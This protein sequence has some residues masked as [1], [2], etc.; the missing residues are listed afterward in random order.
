MEREHLGLNQTQMAR[1]FGKHKNTQAA[2]ESNKKSP[3]AATLEILKQQGVD[4]HFLFYGSPSSAAANE[5]VKQL[6]DVL[7]GLPPGHQAVGFGM[8]SMLR[9]TVPDKAASAKD[10]TATWE[11]VQ[12]FNDYLTLND[13]EQTVIKRFMQSLKD[14]RPPPEGN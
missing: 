1:F 13:E 7:H 2:Y 14:H 5:Q 8:L 4:I 9:N 11:A 10:A 6:L 3:T 12:L